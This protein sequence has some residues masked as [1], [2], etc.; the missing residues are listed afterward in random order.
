M[1]LKRLPRY[2]VVERAVGDFRSQSD[3]SFSKAV[4]DSV[5]TLLQKNRGQGQDGKTDVLTLLPSNI[6]NSYLLAEKEAKPNGTAE[7]TVTPHK[8]DELAKDE[9]PSVDAAEQNDKM[10]VESSSKEG[11]DSVVKSTQV[12][13]EPSV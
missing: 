6:L 2:P 1:F 8:S 9:P 10:D 3:A 5:R 11:A 4:H 7:P 12:D 13:V